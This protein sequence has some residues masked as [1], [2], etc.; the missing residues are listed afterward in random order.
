MHPVE[1]SAAR[2][3]RS[4]GAGTLGMDPGQSYTEDLEGHVVLREGT[5]GHY[6][7]TGECPEPAC[8][9]A[10]LCPRNK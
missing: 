4:V 7:K 1:P 5:G 6:H 8:V 3:L 9:A 2:T 10:A